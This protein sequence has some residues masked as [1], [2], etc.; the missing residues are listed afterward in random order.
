M[1]DINKLNLKLNRKDHELLDRIIRAYGNIMYRE[2]CRMGNGYNDYWHDEDYNI[3]Q[4]EEL[5]Y[6]KYKESE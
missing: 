6:N 4:E 1:I 3:H 5:L 2:G